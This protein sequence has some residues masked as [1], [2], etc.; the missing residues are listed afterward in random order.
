[1]LNLKAYLSNNID[2]IGGSPPPAHHLLQ[3]YCSF[4]LANL[5]IVKTINSFVR[6]NSGETPASFLYRCSISIQNRGWGRGVQ[7]HKLEYLKASIEI[8]KRNEKVLYY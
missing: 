7:G 5:K 8:I 2:F 1:M 3:C 6:E 4:E